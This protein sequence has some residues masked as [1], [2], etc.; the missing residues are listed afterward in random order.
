MLGA[1]NEANGVSVDEFPHHRN[2]DSSA[3]AC[4]VVALPPVRGGI[5]LWWIVLDRSHDEMAE[6]YRSLSAEEMARAQRFGTEP[7]RQRWVVGRAALRLL[8][9]AVLGIEPASV[10]LVRGRRGRPEL[11]G[12]PFDFNV[13]HT[14][15]MAL[16]GIGRALP[17]GLRIGVDV[18]HGERQVNAD[19]LATKFM[20]ARERADLAPLPADERRRGFLRRW[21]AKE[22]MSKATGDAL[23]APFRR[24]EVSVDGG[25]ALTSG[26][27]PYLPED[28]TLSLVTMPGGFLAT[29]AVWESPHHLDAGSS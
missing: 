19:R 20:S 13:S 15:G 16:I 1:R 27:P 24:L 5:E 18:E 4:N 2:L 6:L 17:A 22:A 10:S 7:L 14:C 21:T 23:A 29:V 12:R 9:G 26:P 28:W 25:L 3:A 11:A 8:L